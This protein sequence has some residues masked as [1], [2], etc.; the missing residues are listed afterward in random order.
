MVEFK[1]VKEK[2]EQI[3]LRL[4]ESFNRSGQG[5]VLDRVDA[6]IKQYDTLKE[7]GIIV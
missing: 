4:L 5:N 2:R 1:D 6:A 3:V 7:K